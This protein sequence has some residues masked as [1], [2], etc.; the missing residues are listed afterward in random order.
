MN[1]LARAAARTRL[2]DIDPDWALVRTV[3]D[4]D[5][6]RVQVRGLEVDPIVQTTFCSC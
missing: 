5:V 6:Q 4:P 3:D 2:L 1:P